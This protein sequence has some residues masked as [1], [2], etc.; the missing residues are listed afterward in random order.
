MGKERLPHVINHLKSR[1][2]E[3]I[4][5][6]KDGQPLQGK[7]QE[8]GKGEDKEKV[9]ILF[10]EN[11]VNELLED[12][13]DS[14]GH[15]RGHKPQKNPSNQLS[16]VGADPSVKIGPDPDVGWIFPE[17]KSHDALKP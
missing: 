17:E 13:G 14:R 5:L 4:V 3:N 10:G 12:Q 15:R 16:T 7:K 1:N 8:E 6:V 11:P 9:C 2:A